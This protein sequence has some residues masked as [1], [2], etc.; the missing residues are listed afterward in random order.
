[1]R[2]KKHHGKS[3]VMTRYA[4]RA[5]PGQTPGRIRVPEGALPP[6]IRLTGY[7]PE[8]IA[9]FDNCTLDKV[10]SE[11]GHHPVIWADVT[12]LGDAKLIE[13]FG[14][15]FGIHRLALEDVAHTPQRSKVEVYQDYVFV[16]TQIPCHVEGTHN[17]REGTQTVEQVSFFIGKDFVLSWRE[18][19]GSCFDEVNKRLQVVGGMI[20][21][22]GSDYLLY[23]LLDAA[24]DSYFPVLEKM[25]ERIDTLD[26]EMQSGCAVDLVSR[27]HSVRQD[28]RLL[29]R[30]VW[31]LRE[32]VAS[33]GREHEWLINKETQ[34]YLRDC[35]DHVVQI[36]DSLENYRD[37]CSDLRDYHATEISNR[38]NEIMKVLTIMSTIFIPLGFVAGVYGMN[39]DAE[40][41]P[42]NM[43]ELKWYLGYPMALGLMALVAIGQL[44][45]F[46][47]RGWLGP[48]SHRKREPEN[49][50]H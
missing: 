3:M 17:I 46:R 23:A 40:V 30:V 9:V 15:L 29:R 14:Q 8:K 21:R 41:S 50:E 5:A 37:A 31:P 24:I 47:W 16:V 35:H 6:R 25:G 13:S 43:P 33:L 22:S 12:G 49:S 34:V 11:R 27:I 4:Q 19:A 44:F 28:V 2:K 1:M 45:F 26:D 36:V 32:A 7:G 38:M 20:R 10:R 42:W 39:F 48:G 18:K